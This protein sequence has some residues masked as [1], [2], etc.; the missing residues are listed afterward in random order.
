MESSIFLFWLVVIA[1]LLYMK[2]QPTS[3]V[4]KAAL[5]WIGP[6]PKIGQTLAVF[7]MRW[8]AYAFGWLCQFALMFCALW[9]FAS[10]NSDIQFKWLF[11]LFWFALPLGI[12]I[13]L[14]ST[15]WFV[16]RAAKARYVGPNPNWQGL[17]N[18]D[19]QA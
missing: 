14:A 15:L 5:T 2:R 10:S 8:A 18:E 13:A 19:V 4:A 11:Q 7:Q 9:W 17:Q 6:T 12:G 1:L 3:V 16:A